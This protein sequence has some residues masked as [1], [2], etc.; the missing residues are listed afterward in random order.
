M[1]TEITIKEV[2]YCVSENAGCRADHVLSGLPLCIPVTYSNGEQDKLKFTAKAILASDGTRIAP[3]TTL[4]AGEYEI[5]G[6]LSE[7]CY[8]NPLIFH[9]ADPFIYKHTDGNYYFTA[10][11]TDAEHNLIGEYQYRKILIRKASTINGLGDNSKEYEERCVFER[12]PLIEKRSPHIWA[13]EI[14]FINGDWYIYYTT[15]T[16]DSDSWQIRPHVLKCSGDPMMDEWVNLGPLKTTIEGS[17]AFM[18]FSL[19]HTVLQ[20]KDEL[21]L[22]WAQN[23]DKFS[24]I[25]IAKM[26]D[27]ATI[28]TEMVRLTTPEYEWE[29]YGFSVNEGPSCLV[30]NGK[31]FMIFSCSGTD[32]RY[33]LGMMYA[34]ENAD[35]LN[36][37][38]WTKLD[39]PVFKMSRENGQFGPGHNSFTRSE[40]D[41]YDV[42]VY[43]ARQEER[44]IGEPGYEPLYDAGRNTS[45]MRIH[46]TPDGFPDF[47][48][49]QKNTTD[50]VTKTHVKIKCIIK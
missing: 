26:S 18:S 36:P 41:K 7:T 19:D 33:C 50:H 3:D 31:V 16:S 14:H 1:N 48:V 24:D 46:W 28:C 9:R 32:A 25:W 13:P 30:R 49:P 38:S 4:T 6:F 27:P 47:G 15:T 43:H 5:E 21:Y 35:L 39:Y 45:A 40:D 2:N 8:E 10:S 22:L 44:Y 17:K 29:R 34:A 37:A 23:A 20:H 42:M 11:H 12:E